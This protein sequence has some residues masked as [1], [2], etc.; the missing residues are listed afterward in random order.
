MQ[1]PCWSVGEL[2]VA[3]SKDEVFATNAVDHGH[4]VLDRVRHWP[5]RRVP[6]SARK[7]RAAEYPSAYLL[8]AQNVVTEW[9]KDAHNLGMR[10]VHGADG[11]CIADLARRCQALPPVV[12]VLGWNAIEHENAPCD[13][14]STLVFGGN[15][16]PALTALAATHLCTLLIFSRRNFHGSATATT[17]QRSGYFSA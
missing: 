11:H 12:L 14:V 1:I 16:C 4:A 5:V 3:D 6:L 17:R 2:T 7:S 10:V 13:C 8:F 9:R 15:D